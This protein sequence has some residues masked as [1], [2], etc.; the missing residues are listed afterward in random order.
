MSHLMDNIGDKMNRKD[1]LCSLLVGFGL[2]LIFGYASHSW[3]GGLMV[4]VC[5][6]FGSLLIIKTRNKK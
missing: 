2:G 5:Y 6:L 1:I 3:I 4:G